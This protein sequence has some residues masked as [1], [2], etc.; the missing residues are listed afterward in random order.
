M[1]TRHLKT[2]MSQGLRITGQ[3]P[4]TH[5]PATLLHYTSDPC[6]AK[7]PAYIPHT[8]AHNYIFLCRPR[9]PRPTHTHH[10]YRQLPTKRTPSLPRPT[11]HLPLAYLL[12]YRQ[13]RVTAPHAQSPH[14]DY[15]TS[16]PVTDCLTRITPQIIPRKHS[17]TSPTITPLH[18]YHR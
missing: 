1:Q 4:G 3:D 15:P 12:L 11:T 8:L 9:P 16:P 6:P 5:T 13:T 17:S 18:K 10:S 2:V 7:S 14:H